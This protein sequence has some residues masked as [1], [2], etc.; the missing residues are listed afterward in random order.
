MNK[1]LI[2]NLLI[3][4]VL[5][6]ELDLSDIDSVCAAAKVIADGEWNYYEGNRYGGTLGMFTPPYYWWNAGEAFGGLITYFKFCD[7]N[8]KT[9]EKLL[10]DGMY[11]Q[12]GSDFNYI[13]S[14]QSLVEG[15]DDQGVWGMTIL[16]AA[17]RNLSQPSD[18]HS[19]ISLSQAIY[20]TMNARWDPG[21]CNGGLRWQIFTWNS[22]YDY[23]NTISNGL[24]FHI[25]ARLARY[26][27]NE[28]YVETAEKVWDWMEE[29]GFYT[30]DGDKIIIFDGAK[31]ENNCSDI[32]KIRWSYSYGVFIAGCAYLY[33][34]TKDDKWKTR[35]TDIITTAVD[36]F[37]IGGYM[38]E[39]ACASV[40]RCNND[41]RSFRCLLS[42]CLG[43]TTVLIPETKDLL[44]DYLQKSAT[45][46]AKSCSGGSDGVTCGEDW[47]RGEWDTVYGLGEQM[48]ALEVILANVQD[49]FDPPLTIG[50]G[51]NNDTNANAGLDS[52]D[53]TNS[54]KLKITT[55]DKAGAGVLTAIVLGIILGGSIWMVL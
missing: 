12:T 2:I 4:T 21:N 55:K 30:T 38:A 6:V 26:L 1:W 42:R 53:H 41:Q 50:T 27:D 51:G 22:G 28:T 11:A 33:D 49:Q 16:E 25:A 52:S 31:I 40:N 29:V 9:L 13:P 44:D 3:T 32:T 34:Y 48:S 37:Q 36:Y 24:L 39:T 19:W 7:R 5:G 45:G 18:S 10:I 14:N 43:V 15:N 47:S 46:A 17:E 23:K 54:K 20:N 8:N 35:A